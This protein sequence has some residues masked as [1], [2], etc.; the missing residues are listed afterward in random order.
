MEWIVW[1]TLFAFILTVL[2]FTAL[3]SFSDIECVWP[4]CVSELIKQHK[5]L[6]LLMFGFTTGLHNKKSDNSANT[7]DDKFN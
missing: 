5:S 1:I 7:S 6:T 4:P 3:Y 2:L